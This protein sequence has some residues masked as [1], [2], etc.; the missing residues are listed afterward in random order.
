MQ[1]AYIIAAVLFVLALAGLSRHETAKLGNAAG[2]VGMVIAIAATVAEALRSAERGPVVTGGVLIL[3]AVL[4]GAT[5]GLWRS[6]TVEMTGMPQLIAMLHSFVGLAAVLVGGV[7]SFLDTAHS[8]LAHRIEVAIGVLIGGAYTFTGS[9]VAF[10]KLSGRMK[11]KALMLPGRH[12]LNLLALIAA[13]GCT[14]WFALAP[15]VPPSV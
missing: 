9:L 14:V 8:D 15:A 1:T 2:M 5:I 10:A 6:R 7:G 13:I 4:I 3:V 12:V 11:S